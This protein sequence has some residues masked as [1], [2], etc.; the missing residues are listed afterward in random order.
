MAIVKIDLAELDKIR[1]E[2]ITLTN[3]LEIEK[4]KAS[5]EINEIRSKSKQVL[6]LHKYFKPTI[7]LKS[8]REGKIIITGYRL[9][10]NSP[11]NYDSRLISN[12]YF[13]QYGRQTFD[14]EI[15]LKDAVARGWIELNAEEDI[16][17]V[18]TEY[19]NLNEVIDTIEKQEASK[20]QTRLEALKEALTVS[21]VKYE[22][23]VEDYKKENLRITKKWKEAYEDIQL[24]LK[25]TSDK[26]LKETIEQH[27]A[28]VKTI[29]EEYE[30]KLADSLIEIQ[31]I[32]A[33]YDNLLE[34]Y[35]DYKS[36]RKRV[37]LEQQIEDLKAEL[38]KEKA[39]SFIGKL[40]NK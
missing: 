38:A 19:I 22:T 20:L 12:M 39:K 6:V 31:T 17:K 35:D 8:D 29:S 23:A 16:T 40:F 15:V 14:E 26:V 9:G 11:H 37:S 18:S 1:S 5:N 36:N 25:A 32:N 34:K 30:T 4:T 21:E 28:N 3:K 33:N 27:E 2:V 24:K 7:K 10:N 13:D